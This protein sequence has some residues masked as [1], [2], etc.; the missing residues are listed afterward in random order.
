MLRSM[1]PECFLVPKP[2]VILSRQGLGTRKEP[3]RAGGGGGK[4]V[5]HRVGIL[6]F[7]KKTYQTPHPGQNIM[8]NSMVYFS[9]ALCN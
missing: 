5:W 8:V 1:L 3:G 4:E 7:S 9:T 6:T 2:P